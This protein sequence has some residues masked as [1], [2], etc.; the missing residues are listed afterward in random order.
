MYIEGN[1]PRN[2]DHIQLKN[3]FYRTPATTITTFKETPK[4]STYLL[5]FIVS[6]FRTRGEEDFFVI[7]R[8]EAYNQ[9][10]YAYKVG[11]KLLTKLEEFTNYPYSSHGLGKV[12]LAGI[13]DFSPGAM[14]NWGLLTYRET[15]LLYDTSAS[16]LYDQQ[17]VATVVAHELAH[18]WFGDLVSCEWWGYVWLNEGFGRYFQYF[19]THEVSFGSGKTKRSTKIDR[20][21]NVEIQ[22]N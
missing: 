20:K 11:P 5:A 10:E 17:R 8:P 19:I 15:R 2:V 7:A 4:M 3:L 13:P 1:S 16:T 18:Q 22:K 21:N 14:E 9:T 6:N 12:H